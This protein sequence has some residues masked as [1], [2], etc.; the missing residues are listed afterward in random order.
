MS[1]PSWQP[2]GSPRRSSGRGSPGGGKVELPTQQGRQSSAAAA[3]GAGDGD[4]GW[5]HSEL[6]AAVPAPV[7]GRQVAVPS[8]LCA[9]CPAAVRLNQ[10]PCVLK[11]GQHVTGCNGHQPREDTSL[12]A[13]GWE[14]SQYP[15]TAET[16]PSSVTTTRLDL[17]ASRQW[18]YAALCECASCYVDIGSSQNKK[19]LGRGPA[20]P[21][22]VDVTSPG[23]SV[24]VTCSIAPLPAPCRRVCFVGGCVFLLEASF[25]QRRCRHAPLARY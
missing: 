1:G 2:G 25:W 3:V 14:A 16:A 21:V 15:T 8:Q 19:V 18:G 5:R 24:V 12:S 9:R 20:V 10:R 23:A 11:P 7:I 13:A 6:R 22:G 17:C 4:S